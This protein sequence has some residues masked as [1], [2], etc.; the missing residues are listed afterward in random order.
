MFAIRAGILLACA[1]CVA[2]LAGCA[3]GPYQYSRGWQAPQAVDCEEVVEST[4]EICEG[5]PNRFIDGVG[6]VVGIPGKILLWD[7][8]V[9]NH[10]VSEDTTEAVAQY[11]DDNGLENVCVRVNQYAPGD[12]WR[13]LVDNENVGAGWRY[14][15]GTVSLIGYTLLPGR[16][17]GGDRYNPYTNSVY[18]YSD[19][20]SLAIQS[21]AYGKD[22][23]GRTHPGT[24]AAV[25]QL[26]VVS[27]W[28]ET[29]NTNDA[30]G[31]A[32]ASGDYALEAES[33]RILHPFYGMRVGGAI[34][35][36]IGPQSL[37]VVGGAVAGHI[38]GWINAP[39]AP[40][41]ADAEAEMAATPAAAQA[42]VR[43]QEADVVQTSGS[44]RRT[45]KAS[46]RESR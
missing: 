28:H 16:L 25:N 32:R 26:P 20:P 13:R 5:R 46:S 39:A 37:L 10:C 45:R 43:G 2:G 33:V 6:W 44:A 4:T 22:V 24:Y 41:E 29:I 1:G 9:N 27:L 30:L 3:S 31:Y 19:V 35:S 21:A 15:L 40:A 38:S 23:Q 36:V 18:V 12:E 8:R 7:R 34:G 42:V 17:L 11:I 14:T